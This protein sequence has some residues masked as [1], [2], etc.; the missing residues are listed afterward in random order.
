MNAR[1][2][3]YIA[4]STALLSVSAWMAIPLGGV[5]ITVQIL[6]LCLTAGLLGAKR[7][8]LATL[9][10]LLLG[11]IGVPVFAGFSGGVRVLLS[12]TGGY[13]VGFLP[14]SFLVGLM[15]E[16]AA[17]KKRAALWLGVFMG[18]G[19]LSCYVFGTVWF[20]LISAQESVTVG[21]W[22]ALTLCVFPYIPLDAVKI[23]FAVLLV[24][25][26]RKIINM[27]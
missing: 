24:E 25:K 14:L 4:V 19:V 27:K 17:K 13:L 18:V 2:L 16:R 3:G 12:P 26:L 8:V 6:V 11:F 9:A 23:F 1:D 10:Y 5:P 7:A 15:G 22:S 20:V 21:L